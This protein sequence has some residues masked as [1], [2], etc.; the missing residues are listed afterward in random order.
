MAALLGKQSS[1][2]ASQRAVPGV[3]GNSA[4]SPATAQLAWP[5]ELDPLS[6]MQPTVAQVRL[7]LPHCVAASH[8]AEMAF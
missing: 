8:K 3:P 7:S 5:D 6:T 1:Q 4:Q 2:T